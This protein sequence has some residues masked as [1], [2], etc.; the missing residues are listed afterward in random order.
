MQRTA[1]HHLGFP[2][3]PST[4]AYKLWCAIELAMQTG[5]Q[6]VYQD[7]KQH[8]RTSDE[9]PAKGDYWEINGNDVVHVSED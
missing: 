6:Y 5:K 7:Y 1:Y 8:W 9:P 4:Y 3:E 2:P